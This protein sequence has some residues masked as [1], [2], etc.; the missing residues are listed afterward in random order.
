MY[1]FPAHRNY[2]SLRNSTRRQ[3]LTRSLG[4]LAP[5]QETFGIAGVRRRAI[6][7]GDQPPTQWALR[8]L[9]VVAVVVVV[10]RKALR[11]ECR[12]LPCHGEMRAPPN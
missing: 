10:G 3:Q 6:E 2:Q 8:S 9:W 12:R 11:R 1:K 4:S 5:G 7:M